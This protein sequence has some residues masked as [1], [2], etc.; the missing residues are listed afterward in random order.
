MNLVNKMPSV[1]SAMYQ[2]K[3]EKDEILHTTESGKRLTIK[4]RYYLD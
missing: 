3:K 4:I 1:C 2:L